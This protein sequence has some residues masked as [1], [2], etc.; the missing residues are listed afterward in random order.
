MFVLVPCVY[1]PLNKCHQIADV[2]AVQEINQRWFLQVLKHLGV[3]WDGSR[4]DVNNIAIFFNRH[5]VEVISPSLFAG[6]MCVFFPG[7]GGKKLHWRKFMKVT[8]F[9]MGWC[10]VLLERIFFSS[11][12]KISGEQ[13]CDVGKFSSQPGRSLLRPSKAGPSVDSGPTFI[14]RACVCWSMVEC[15]WVGGQRNRGF[16]INLFGAKGM[17]WGGNRNTMTRAPSKKN[18]MMVHRSFV[19]FTVHI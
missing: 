17:W 2:F 1:M 6:E 16:P 9:L 18:W 7:G 12:R 15:G 13:G 4:D 11:N 5:K 3:A 19:L 10:N 14:D 8:V